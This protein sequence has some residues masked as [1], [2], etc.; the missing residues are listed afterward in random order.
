MKD[1][2]KVVSCQGTADISEDH[3][4][5]PRDYFKGSYYRTAGC[6]FA[7]ETGYH[8]CPDPETLR[9]VIPEEE[10]WPIFDKA[11]EEDPFA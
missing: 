11:T 8:G 5:G 6:H 2:A 9:K 4:W 7:S 10:L 1:P 3:L